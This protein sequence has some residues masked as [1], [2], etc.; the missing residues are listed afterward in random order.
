MFTPGVA[1]SL[2]V[3]AEMDIGSFST[4]LADVV[5]RVGGSIVGCESAPRVA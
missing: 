3:E 1:R 4:G 2:S 5:E